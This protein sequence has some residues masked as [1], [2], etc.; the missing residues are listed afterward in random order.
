MGFNPGSVSLPL[1][2]HSYS[3]NESIQFHVETTFQSQGGICDQ[4]LAGEIQPFISC[5]GSLKG[6]PTGKNE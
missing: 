4:F 1:N 5:I 6:I 3:L 2:H